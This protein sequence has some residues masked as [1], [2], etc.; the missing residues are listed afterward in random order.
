[1]VHH[2]ALVLQT[3]LT[4]T[5]DCTVKQRWHHAEFCEF[6]QHQI[7]SCWRISYLAA[8]RGLVTR[9]HIATRSWPRND[10]ASVY[11]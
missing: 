11:C 4:F 6:R 7:E 3:L 2:A 8:D 5:S 10:P 1:M 9:S